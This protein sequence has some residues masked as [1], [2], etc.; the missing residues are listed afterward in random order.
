[1]IARLPPKKQTSWF[2]SMSHLMSSSVRKNIYI[3]L[4]VQPIAF[5]NRSAASLLYDMPFSHPMRDSGTSQH[6]LQLK[7]EPVA[8]QT[9]S[10]SVWRTNRLKKWQTCQWSI[11]TVHS[12]KF[13]RQYSKL[14]LDILT[15][16][17]THLSECWGALSLQPTWPLHQSL[18]NC[19]TRFFQKMPGMSTIVSLT[20]TLTATRRLQP[21]SSKTC[22][23]KNCNKGSNCSRLLKG[24]QPW[25][26]WKRSV[27]RSTCV[28]HGFKWTSH[29]GN[30]TVRY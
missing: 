16:M 8:W 25:R 6:C 23:A 21:S 24:V 13:S 26:I 1:M 18:L 4:P 10:G 14:V 3:F 15:T 2:G 9:S 5:S 20:S 7:H 19:S 11:N 22:R 30:E 17:P 28:G 27:A 12:L 29:E